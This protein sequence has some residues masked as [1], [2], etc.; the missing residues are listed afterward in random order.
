M[1]SDCT[2]C[3]ASRHL[4]NCQHCEASESCSNCAYVL[5]SIRLTGCSYCFGCVGLCGADFHILNQPYAR[6]EYFALTRELAR[7][8][9]RG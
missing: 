2:Q 8:L 9:A 1:C 7:E 3:R 4:V 6:G 5:H